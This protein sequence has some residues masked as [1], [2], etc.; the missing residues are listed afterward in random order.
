MPAAL[1]WA[2]A[3]L[4]RTVVI[5]ALALGAWVAMD[6]LVGDL[7]VAFFP[8][9]RAGLRGL[10][11]YQRGRYAEAARAYRDSLRGTHR[12]G[13]ADDPAGASAVAV[14]DLGTA[15]RWARLTLDLVPSALEPRVTLAEV[16]LERGDLATAGTML[17]EVLRRRPDHLDALYLSALVQAR[18]GAIDG[19]I[20]RLNRGLVRSGV[21]AS[22]PV[23]LWRVLEL[24]GELEGLP[25]ARR[26]ACLLAHL[27]RYVRIYDPAQAARITA[28]ARAA[29]AR[30]D[31]SADAWLSIGIVEAR[32]G[33]PD[34]ATEAMRTSF[35]LDP[36]QA[37]AAAWLAHDAWLRHD[38][39]ARQRMVHAAF[40]ARPTDPYFMGYVDEVLVRGLGDHHGVARLMER[41]LAVDPDYVA[42]HERLAAAALR[43][44][45]HQR[46]GRH[47]DIAERLAARRAAAEAAE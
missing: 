28:H 24:I 10:I 14:G 18:R 33:R 40:S 26:P 45:D 9:S 25:E 36:R 38:V 7:D 2:R 27:L 19:A 4:S 34:A 17:D 32:L 3:A 11:L 15:G 31:R 41:A 22:R 20:E 44:G 35:A 8:A 16:A 5:V 21:T 42:A 29:I 12:A 30:G 13:Y 46:A 47:R 37:E 6:R 1:T 43:L 39:L 23:L